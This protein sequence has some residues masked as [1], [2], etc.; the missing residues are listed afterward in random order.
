MHCNSENAG[1]QV[2]PPDGPAQDVALWMLGSG[3]RPV[4]LIAQFFVGRD[5]VTDELIRDGGKKPRGMEWGLKQWTP[6]EILR[7]YRSYP[8]DGLGF[9]SGLL[10][11]G[12]WIVCLDVDDPTV[13]APV[14]ARM[15]PD[16]L[17]DTLGWL[18]N[19]GNQHVFLGDERLAAYKPIVKGGDHY[20]GI[21]LRIGTSDLDDP[22]QVQS[23]CP[24]SRRLDGTPR[25]WIGGPEIL[26]LPES[27]YIDLEKYAH[28]KAHK[29]ASDD[30]GERTEASLARD[31]ELA[32]SA[33][34][35]LH[36]K[37]FSDGES[38]RTIAFAL[39]SL[40]DAGFELFDS[41][42]AGDPDQ[43][44]GRRELAE[45]WNSWQSQESRG[46]GIGLGTLF[47]LAG[48][49]GWIRPV[50]SR[51]IFGGHNAAGGADMSNCETT[52]DGERPKIIIDVDEERCGD[53][54]VKGLAG[55]P[56][57][58]QR[59][60]RLVTILRTPLAGKVKPG[61]KR[62]TG[63]P[64]IDAIEAP[65]LREMLSS[66]VQWVKIKTDKKGM[67]FES[68][69]HIPD[70]AT[71]AIMA[72]K[73]WAGIRPLM[74]IVECPAM[75]GGGELLNVAGYHA[76]S[77]LLYEPAISFP[78]VPDPPTLEDA[79][80]AAQS[81]LAT[82]A[83][84]PFVGAEDRAAWLAAC[85]TPLCRHAING[86]CP[87]FT[88]TANSPGSGKTLLF[89]LISIVATGRDIAKTTL[90]DSEDEMRKR[91][92]SIALEGDPM[93][94]I[95]NVDG[96]IGGPT[97]DAALTSTSWKDR[98]LGRSAMTGD[99]PLNTIWFATGNQLGY[100]GD[101]V[102]RVVP[103]RLNT[104]L[105]RPE[106]RSDFQISGP[107]R[108]YVTR[109]R[110]RLVTAGLTILK[111]HHAAGSPDCGLKPLGGFEAW[112][113]VV[114]NA[115]MWATR[116]DPLVT[117]AGLDAND[118][119]A[120]ERSAIVSGWAELPGS[121]VG[122][123]VAEALA[124]IEPSLSPTGGSRFVLRDKNPYPRLR[125]A[126]TG[127]DGKL[128]SPLAVSGRLR[129]IRG[130]VTEGLRL[131]N[132]IA[133]GGA[134]KWF[135]VPVPA[136]DDGDGGDVN[137]NPFAEKKHSYN[138]K[139]PENIGG[140]EGGECHHRHQRHQPQS[141]G[142]TI[143]EQFGHLI[144]GSDSLDANT[145]FIEDA[146]EPLWKLAVREFG[147]TSVTLPHEVARWMA[148]GRFMKVGGFFSQYFQSADASK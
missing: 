146:G 50:P 128:L 42:S 143:M 79:H 71:A 10:P 76:G 135:V 100:K 136:G 37:D 97:L 18:A 8:N 89:D 28:E 60:G 81:L 4:P 102:R 48:E 72:R 92:T 51:P 104:D 119:K 96:E 24:P 87:M 75:L 25:T 35:S 69:V 13:A 30:P 29:P 121:D 14:L 66:A 123:T 22:K 141:A 106:E 46:D 145:E 68:L 52:N 41:W 43:Y 82:V 93:V 27:V 9:M 55:N 95:D 115:V 40:G 86:P 118:A 58:Y 130:R 59:A 3:Y 56:A 78:P 33:L 90:P 133:H 47:L 131:E 77:G 31:I 85:L 63:S 124:F 147:P 67:K 15:F 61:L 38:W 120:Q 88:A 44:P 126:F 109:E 26:P 94:L 20:Q 103:I 65:R 138:S 91:V 107:I 114:R 32:R 148:S 17:P 139:G 7:H 129:K 11:D 49:A 134:A 5:P 80:K 140:S 57:I 127:R 53:E 34:A 144:D 2:R 125:E 108:A 21:E 19:R 39:E 74:A 117:R 64:R 105:E 111:A 110:G 113:M 36:I 1:K 116:L 137:P 73:A 99:M 23:A 70:W 84:F 62:P 12:R 98:L 54:A 122:L 112:S 45:K 6:A 142:D 101:T 16:G 83:D 132:R